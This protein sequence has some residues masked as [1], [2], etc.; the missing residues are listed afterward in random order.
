MHQATV[1][2]LTHSHARMKDYSANESR[3]LVV[4]LLTTLTMV[5]EILAGYWTGSMALLA[6]GWHMGTHTLAL[7]LSYVAY[8][9]A[10]FFEGS[11]RFSFGTGKMGILAGYTSALFL[12]FAA[13]WM[14]YESICRIVD[15]VAIAFSE[16]IGITF[17]GLVVNL[18][19]VLILNSSNSDH[20][21]HS[22][23]SIS[24]HHHDH[25][26]RAAYL[27]VIADSLTSILALIALLSGR[28]FGWIFLDP[29]MGIVGGVLICCW[30]YTL[31]KSTGSILLDGEAEKDIRK[32]IYDLIESDNDSRIID[33]HVWHIG[34]NEIACIASI[35]TGQNL[36]AEDYQARIN[37]HFHFHHI[38]VEVHLCKIESCDCNYG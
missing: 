7:G 19:S 8:R 12:G 33:L 10:H 20:H 14:I 31:L 21:R 4:V 17:I 35:V 13:I 9:L 29:I 34:S 2:R 18:A 26:Y 23:D 30:A 36:T 3:T 27:H 25:N 28:Y 24:E 22:H 11:G 6:D 1:E 16:A 38:S 5:I 37:K 15:P 32:K